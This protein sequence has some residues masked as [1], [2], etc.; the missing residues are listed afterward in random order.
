ML[1]L[2]QKISLRHFRLHLL[3]TSLTVLGIALGITVF[4]GINR[5]NRST[6]ASFREMINNVAGRAQIEVSRG[7]SGFEE[8]VLDQIKGTYGVAKATPLVRASA[9]L[10]QAAHDTVILLGVDVLADKD[11][12]TFTAED[13][14][15]D[16]EEVD[17]LAFLNT[18]DSVL[19]TDVL[20]KRY[21]I[22]KGDAIRVVTGAG[23]RELKVQAVLAEKGA[24]KVFG[25]N[26]LIMDVF[27]AQTLLD[28]EGRFDQV[29]II[30]KPGVPL[31]TVMEALK[32]K[33]GEGFTIGHPGSRSG[34][35]ENMLAS[36]QQ[37]LDI[38]SLLALFVGMFLIYN[39]FS[40]AVA[41][42]RREIGIQR[43]LGVSAKQIR[44][45]FLLEAVVL[46][47][48]GSLLGT[49]AGYVLAR[50][51]TQ[52]VAQTISTAYFKLD[53]REITVPVAFLLQVL[54]LGIGSSMLASYFPARQ[55]A[56]VSPLE[57]MSPMAM[58]SVAKRNYVKYFVAG[59]V[60]LVIELSLFRLLAESSDLAVNLRLALNGGASMLGFLALTLLSPI[61]IIAFA[62]FVSPIL[63]RLAGVEG[64]L[65]AD[66]LTRAPGRTSVTVSAL[67]I[68]IAL[69][70]AVKGTMLSFKAS[71]EEWL[72][73]SVT[74]DLVIRSSSALPGPDAVDMPETL[75]DEIRKVAGVEAVNRFRMVQQE[76][77]GTNVVLYSVEMPVYRQYSPGIW[78][79]GKAD[80]VYDAVT[81]KN[82]VYVSEN[83]MNR[84]G[85]HSGDEI[86]LTTPSGPQRFRI[87]G[88]RVDYMSDQ[89]VIGMDRV[90]F[91]KYWK[92]NGVDSYDVFLAP[93]AQVGAVRDAIATGPGKPYRLVLQTN[94]EYRKEVENAIDQSFKITYAMELIAI[95]IAV[96]GI[97]NTLMVSVLDRTREIGMLRAIGFTREQV[98]KLVVSEA[99][100]MG[101]VAG[102]FGA[103]A[104]V[105]FSLIITRVILRSVIGWTTPFVF[106]T[107]SMATGMILAVVVSMASG[108][109]PAWK[110][111]SANI[112]RALEYE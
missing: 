81:A 41:Q 13:D 16:T 54:A 45:L 78:V 28:R 53:I 4:V 108:F 82:A 23:L 62:E 101:V 58:E 88:V 32:K 60:M 96:I 20:A 83:F 110:A 63:R 80:R 97:I 73:Q 42:R 55:A 51:L 25:G 17:P 24:A 49:G 92:D 89:G 12:R 39:T 44:N 21:S 77:Q 64:R 93:G 102:V 31:E 56:R 2:L 29:D 109:Y 19:I 111:A 47:L 22:H 100:V 1:F 37:I 30:V 35:V 10:E 107:T 87:E 69:S 57:A 33:L 52:V 71:V 6:L 9:Y 40:M 70:V 5:V 75:G 86:E 46:G 34:Q 11:F 76:Y 79:E 66:N 67:M 7:R 48:V 85:V 74:A 84:F 99:G 3:R 105:G 26:L 103:F 36:F 8:A 38:M 68:G 65:G 61:L 94:A 106:P 95:I 72:H 59:V 112:I 18:P 90:I 98:R 50:E 43:A 14:T 91:K 27:N 104:G 15:A